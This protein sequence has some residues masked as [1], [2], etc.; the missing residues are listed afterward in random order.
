MWIKSAKNLAKVLE[1]KLQNPRRNAI[2]SYS[3]KT[4][5]GIIYTTHA[6]SIYS[7]ITYSAEKLS[8][9]TTYRN[10]IPYYMLTS[11]KNLSLMYE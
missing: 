7:V 3:H 4:K 9:K 10:A 2:P 5:L 11:Y 8:T 6:S 1:K